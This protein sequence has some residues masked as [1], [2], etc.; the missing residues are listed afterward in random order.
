MKVNAGSF[1]GIPLG[2]GRSFYQG[3]EANGNLISCNVNKCPGTKETLEYR[4]GGR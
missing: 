4:A 3:W 1:R 2:L